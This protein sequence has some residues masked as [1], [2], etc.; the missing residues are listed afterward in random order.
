MHVEVG[1]RTQHLRQPHRVL[2][3]VGE[4]PG[5]AT[6]LMTREPLTITEAV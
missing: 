4:H 1:Q 5:G 2:L 3:G 6:T